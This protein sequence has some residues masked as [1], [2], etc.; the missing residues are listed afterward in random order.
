MGTL[1][2][3]GLPSTAVPPFLS[4]LPEITPYLPPVSSTGTSLS[5]LPACRAVYD[6]LHNV[7]ELSPVLVA[8]A[9]Y[10]V[11]SKVPSSTIKHVF[12]QPAPCSLLLKAGHAPLCTP[13]VRQYESKPLARTQCK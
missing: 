4:K 10:P 5:I 6:A 3:L 13:W 7:T 11:S 9:F 2:A 8:A 12:S 1:R